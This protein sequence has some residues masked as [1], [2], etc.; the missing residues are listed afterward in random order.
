VQ[1]KRK[2]ILLHLRRWFEPGCAVVAGLRCLRVAQTR[3]IT[4]LSPRR[5]RRGRQNCTC[6]T[7]VNE[8][9][10]EL[11][12][13]LSGIKASAMSEDSQDRNGVD[14]RRLSQAKKERRLLALRHPA[15]VEQDV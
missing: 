4:E 7:N 13:A 15:D 12:V 10:P 8:A 6:R 2:D 14:E 3:A 11:D 5:A 1:D 9:D